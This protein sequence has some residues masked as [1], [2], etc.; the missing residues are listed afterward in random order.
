[1][2]RLYCMYCGKARENYCPPCGEN[3]LATAAEVYA[4]TGEW[5]EDATEDEIDRELDAHNGRQWERQQERAMQR[6]YP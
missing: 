4:D 2:S 1:M 3:H 5:P 6:G